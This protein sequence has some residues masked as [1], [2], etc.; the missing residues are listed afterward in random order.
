MSETIECP[1]PLSP[2]PPQSRKASEVISWSIILFSVVF[3]AWTASVPLEVPAETAAAESAEPPQEGI[4]IDEANEL[5]MLKMQSRMLIGLSRLQPASVMA[6]I[7]QLEGMASTTRGKA[8]VAMVYHFVDKKNGKENALELLEKIDSEDPQ[9]IEFKQLVQSAIENGVNEQQRQELETQVG[10]FSGM[11]ASSGDDVDDLAREQIL[12]ESSKSMATIFGFSGIVVL[13]LLAG[14]ILLVVFVILLGNRTV[15]MQYNAA[16]APALGHVF[17]E[18]FAV[19][20]GI[21]ALGHILGTY[22]DE[23]LSILAYVGSFLLALFWPLIRGVSWKQTRELVGMHRGTGFFRE[24]GAGILGYLGI[25]VFA[26]AGLFLTLILMAVVNLIQSGGAG[27]AGVAGA[28][29]PIVGMLDSSESLASKIQLLL[30]AA[31]AAPVLEEI[32]FRGA[33]FRYLRQKTGFIV[34][35]LLGGVIFAIIHP[36]GI[37]A[38]PALTSMGF[39]FALIREWRD[40]LIAPMTAHALNNGAIVCL[41]L[42]V[43]G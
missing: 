32:M 19:Y 4:T 1:P 21:M 7:N 6:S 13:A 10:W 18:A 31:V 2:E 28:S 39:G 14:F 12:A 34:C 16:K 30:L 8:A 17:L 38:L 24:V 33:L 5:A 35:G 41:L 29:H 22:V 11:L 40:S 23:R 3:L 25:I 27:D 42:L 36:Q 43:I 15:S 20:I 26:A 9:S 37:L